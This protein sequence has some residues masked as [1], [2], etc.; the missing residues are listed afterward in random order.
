M[1]IQANLRSYTYSPK[2]SFGFDSYRDYDH[3]E[4]LDILN[5]STRWQDYT[6]LEFEHLDE[7]SY[8]K[9]LGK[10]TK[11][12]YGYNK[13]C[14]HIVYTV[15]HDDSH[16]SYVVA[17]GHLTYVPLTSFYSGVVNLWGLRLVLFHT[18]LTI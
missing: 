17:A 11:V 2:Y 18:K 16:K 13:I 14:T 6:D 1:V 4:K 10:L 12:P 9:D 8:F 7:Y 5:K 15:K 3:A